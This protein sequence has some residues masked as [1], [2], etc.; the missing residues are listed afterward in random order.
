LIGNDSGGDDAT[1]LWR[2]PNPR[3]LI[4]QST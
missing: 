3:S 1:S 4:G 2:A